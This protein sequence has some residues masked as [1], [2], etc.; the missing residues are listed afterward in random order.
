MLTSADLLIRDGMKP[1]AL[2]GV[3]GGLDTEI[4][5]AS[6][7]VMVESAVFRPE[8]IRKTARRLALASEASYRF[9][10]GVDQINS[11]F[12]MDRAVSLM[13]EL[14]GGVVRTGAC[15]QEPKLWAAP[16]F[17]CSAYRGSAR[18]GCRARVLRGYAGTSGL[19]P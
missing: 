1:V 6:R 19:R 16:A 9:E 17:P 4:S 5:D 2:A 10:R 18:H 7:N 12:A 8:T 14:S 13:A 15:T 11:R 3:M